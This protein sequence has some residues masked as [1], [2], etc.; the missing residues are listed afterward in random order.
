MAR[1]TIKKKLRRKKIFKSLV[2]LFFCGVF[3]VLF[4]LYGPYKGF[5][6]WLITNAMTTMN[7]QYLA[8]WFY[9]DEYISKVLENNK[10]VEVNEATDTSK[11]TFEIDSDSYNNDYEKQVVSHN[12]NQLYKVININEGSLRGYLVAIYDA[13]K[14]SVKTTKSLGS[15]GQYLTKM[16]E[17]KNA[18]VAINASGFED[19]GGVGT[20]GSPNGYVISD[21]KLVWDRYL[22][23]TMVGFNQDNV[24]VIGKYNST[25]ALNMGIRDAVN[26]GPVLVVNGKASSVYGN[27]GWGHANRTAIGQRQDGIVLF[28]VMDG[29]DYAAGVPG[30]SMSDLIDLMLRYGAYNAINL[31]GGTSSN[32]VINNKLVNK[33]MNG[34]FQNKTRPIATSFMLIDK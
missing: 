30:P 24:L 1:K 29:R 31:D 16:A 11:I 14:I 18:L 15:Y 23:G 34:S 13:S 28:L 32:L 5:S 27:G 8:T 10:T 25:Q 26:F 3:S 4:L 7:H 21:G 22:Y 2:I 19:E 20:G 33:V 17:D 9:S 6:D 12:K